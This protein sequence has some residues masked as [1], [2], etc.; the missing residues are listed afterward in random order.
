MFLTTELPNENTVHF[1][2]YFFVV[3]TL[4]SMVLTGSVAFNLA[5]GVPRLAISNGLKVSKAEVMDVW[6]SCGWLLELRSPAGDSELRRG[7]ESIA[8]MLDFDDRQFMYFDHS[9]ADV[10]AACS[11]LRSMLLPPLL[12]DVVAERRLACGNTLGLGLWLTEG[13]V[14]LKV[15]FIFVLILSFKIC[16]YSPKRKGWIVSYGASQR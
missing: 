3:S 12:I 5:D 8:H 1:N 13:L 4:S 16:L 9:A 6:K 14:L 15:R 7:I 2:D 10:V 11:N